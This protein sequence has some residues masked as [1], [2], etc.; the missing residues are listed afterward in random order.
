MDVGFG[1][2]CRRMPE[3]ALDDQNINILVAK[4]RSHAACAAIAESDGV[5]RKVWHVTLK[6][7]S[8]LVCIRIFLKLSSMV[9]PSLSAMAAQDGW[10]GDC[11]F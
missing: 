10:P 7:T 8:K 5:W 1:A 4:V 9:T 2:A 11:L 3:D 6:G